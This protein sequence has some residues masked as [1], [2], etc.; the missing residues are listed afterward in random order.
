MVTEANRGSHFGNGT[1][2]EAPLAKCFE[3]RLVK[4]LVA[5]AFS[6]FCIGHEPCLAIDMK[7]DDT[8]TFRPTT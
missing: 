3:R 4:N 7:K 5:C 2:F 6:H 1:R 8:A